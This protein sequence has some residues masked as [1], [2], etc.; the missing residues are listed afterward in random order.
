MNKKQIIEKI[1]NVIFEILMDMLIEFLNIAQ[2]L[3]NL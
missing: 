1:M 2:Y 3:L